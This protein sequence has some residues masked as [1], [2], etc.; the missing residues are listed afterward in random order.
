MRAIARGKSS[1][2]RR[3]VVVLS[4]AILVLVVACVVLVKVN[5]SAYNLAKSVENS[6]QYPLRYT[7]YIQ[8]SATEHE[9]NPYWVCAVIKAESD[10]DASAESDAGAVGLMQMLPSTAQEMADW[11][12]VDASVYPVEDLADPRVNI[13]Y[14]TA[15]LR[16]LVERYHEMEPAIAAYNAGMA[17]VD[18]WLEN[19]EDIRDVIE[20]PE[21][22]SYLLEVVWNKERYETLYPD[23]FGEQ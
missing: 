19:G 5:T 1:K 21:T 6:V 9:V 15:Y 20:F 3:L 8:Q 11:G 17:N 13:E 7:E 4:V 18:S 12:L 14:G 2:H 10:W 23:A 16:Y 22:D